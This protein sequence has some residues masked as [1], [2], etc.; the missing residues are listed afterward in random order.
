MSAAHCK[1]RERCSSSDSE[2]PMGGGG[3]GGVRNNQISIEAFLFRTKVF[4]FF[5]H[6]PPSLVR[7]SVT[8]LCPALCNSMDY[9]LQARISEWVD[10]PFSRTKLYILNNSGSSP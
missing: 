5:L 10:I 2:N 8:Q 9:T 3:G 4:I 7:C 1:D 6:P